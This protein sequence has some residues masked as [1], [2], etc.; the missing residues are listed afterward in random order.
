MSFGTL[1]TLFVVPVFYTVIV[2]KIHLTPEEREAI[3]AS[4]GA[5]VVTNPQDRER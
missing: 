4:R 5:G 1:L 2:R 3:Q